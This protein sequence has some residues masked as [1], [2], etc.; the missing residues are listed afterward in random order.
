VG[1]KQ[2]VQG[3]LFYE[4][5]YDALQKMVHGNAYD[6]RMKEIASS[7]FPSKKPETARNTLSRALAEEYPDVNLNPGE[8]VKLMELSG[9]PEDVIYYLCDRFN[10]ERPPRKIR[11]SLKHEV[12]ERFGDIQALMSDLSR[13][14][15]RLRDE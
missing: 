2:K 8:M 13:K 5:I 9:R 3:K 4:D 15:D 14:M 11:D 1:E 10:F 6:L 12:M 7:L